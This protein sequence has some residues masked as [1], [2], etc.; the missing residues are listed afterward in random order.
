M[1]G[2]GGLVVAAAVLHG[3]GGGSCPPTGGSM[4]MSQTLV[5]HQVRGGR[6]LRGDV[7]VHMH[8]FFKYF[9]S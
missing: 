8:A 6:L 7:C 2:E 9:H 1:G 3:G 5:L 4:K